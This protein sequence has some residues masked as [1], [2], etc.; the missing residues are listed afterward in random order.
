MRINVLFLLLFALSL[1]GCEKTKP[2]R[3]VNL[4]KISELEKTI[5]VNKRIF[6]EEQ[7]LIKKYME[8]DSTLVYNNSGKGFWYAYLKKV[9]NST[10][11]I[12][13]DRVVFEEEILGL[14]GTILYAKKDLGL[15]TYVLDKEHI[16]K[17]LKEGI[18][19][20]KEGEEVKFLFSSFVAYRMN[21]DT[22]HVIGS[23]KPV[24]STIKLIKIN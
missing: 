20:M 7:N 17:G 16:I 18:K 11:P 6:S 24:I 15:R 10:Y 12:K 14:D 5:A 22:S 4:P 8:L 13:G 21:G 1:G 2:R 19:L 9:N 3:D 23:N